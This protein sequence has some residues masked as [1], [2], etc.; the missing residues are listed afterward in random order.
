M[1][2]AIARPSPK[3]NFDGMIGCWRVTDFHIY[4]RASTFEGKKY[5]AG[6]KRRKDC[7]MDG[8]K[9]VQMMKEDVL[10]AIRRKLP[11]ASSV[12]L[13]Y[14]NAGPH[15][16]K[17]S[18]KLI[19]ALVAKKSRGPKITIF[20]QERNSPCTNACDLGFNKSLDSR[21]PHRRAFNLDKFEKQILAACNSYPSEKLDAIFDMK[22]RVLECII[23]A[24]GLNDFDLP[25]RKKC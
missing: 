7:N 17:A 12:A 5:R 6:D 22:S 11:K 19:N 24:K 3:H 20:K 25:H 9:F 2:C 18:V 21:L 1:L 8:E 14:D 23:Q 15:V 16:S 10:P 13:Q 4:K